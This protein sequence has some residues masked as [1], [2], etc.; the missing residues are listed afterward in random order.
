MSAPAFT[1]P[2]G[3]P[4][5]LN[6]AAAKFGTISSDHNGQ[7]AAFNGQV[8][9]ALASWRGPVAEQFA[10]LAGDTARRYTA[11]VTALTS[12]QRALTTYAGALQTAQYT[13]GSLNRQVAAKNSA[14][15]RNQ[16]AR[17]LSG[18]ESAAAA[19]LSQA[20][21]TCARALQAAHTTLAAQCPDI[22]SAQ[23]FAQAIKNAENRLNHPGQA[24]NPVSLYAGLEYMLTGYAL[25]AA[26]KGGV[27][28]AEAG[29]ELTESEG[30]LKALQ[31]ELT[32]AARALIMSQVKDPWEQAA[33]LRAWEGMTLSVEKEVTDAKGAVQ[34][35]GGSFL[36]GMLKGENIEIAEQGEH[37]ASSSEA[38]DA[39][40]RTSKL[41][42]ILAPVA[43]AFGIHDLI[44][45]P[46]QTG[47]ER[48]GNRIAGGVGAFGGALALATWAAALFGVTW[49]IPV[50]D[51]GTG[52]V[53]GV[54]LVAAGLWAAGDAVYDFRHQI[55]DGIKDAGEWAWHGIENVGK[56]VWDIPGEAVHGLENL[57]DP[58][59]W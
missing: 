21:S 42:V 13:I 49:E 9:T 24:D 43:I 55:W 10:V 20:A 41:D 7:L 56:S 1:V 23:Q 39:L 15:G 34:V 48:T 58:L 53:A 19:T 22:M 31:T 16:E 28:G 18:Q 2:V 52:T 26:A 33:L 45:P 5:T 57:A 27:K 14:S 6:Q 17:S 36:E 25:F 32:P 4:A 46:G 59:D 30:L 8:Q 47:W 54:M 40:F 38:L 11:V 35:K 12:I 3:D 50:V 29:A 44:W 51:V 37:V